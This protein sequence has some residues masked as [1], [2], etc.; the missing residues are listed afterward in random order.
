MQ[1]TELSLSGLPAD[2]L[3]QVEHAGTRLV[4]VR[5]KD[6][7][8]AFHDVCPHAFWPLSEGSVRHTVLECAGHGWEFDLET[9][10]CLSTPTYCLT[11][12]AVKVD[13]DK[14]HLEW[15]DDLV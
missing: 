7:V 13:G 14:V 1:N 4:V 8:F 6:K 2:S 11:P 10:R 12:V 3:H 9:G 15:P 5:S